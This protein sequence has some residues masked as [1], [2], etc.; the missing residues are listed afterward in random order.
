MKF[1]TLLYYLENTSPEYKALNNQLNVLKKKKG[2]S[3][4]IMKEIKARATH[5]HVRGN[6]LAL[7]KKLGPGVPEEIFPFGNEYPK[8]RLGFAKWLMDK[9]NP[10]TAR[11]T[12][13]RYWEQL[14]GNGIVS[15]SEEFG[16]QGELP[17]HPKLLDW[18]ANYLKANNWDTKK[19]IKLIVSSASY[20]QSSK[21]VGNIE[22]DPLNRLLSRGPA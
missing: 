17:S 12:A 9:N 19:L 14:F 3:V 16:S 15:T 6:Y 11:V 2:P 7:G 10:M 1:N 8:N 20:Q 18:M 13:N 22:R 21:V 4:P 5:L